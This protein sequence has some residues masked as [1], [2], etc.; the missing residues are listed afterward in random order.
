MEFQEKMLSRFTDLQLAKTTDSKLP[1]K[2]CGC[3]FLLLQ[4]T[5]WVLQYLVFNL[6]TSFNNDFLTGSAMVK[7]VL[8]F[9]YPI[10]NSNLEGTL[11]RNALNT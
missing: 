9:E 11:M 10:W 2:N 7:I 3:K 4:K 6:K 5:V 8:M 1:N